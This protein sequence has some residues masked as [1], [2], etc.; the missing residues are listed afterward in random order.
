M[1]NFLEAITQYMRITYL[2]LD[3][4]LVPLVDDY[5]N[6][7]LMQIMRVMVDWQVQRCFLR[8]TLQS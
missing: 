5:F 3:S 2:A 1:P 7:K 8:L 4:Q 6:D